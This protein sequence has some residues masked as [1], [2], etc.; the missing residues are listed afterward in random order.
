MTL[1]EKTIL[2]KQQLLQLKSRFFKNDPPESIKDRTF[3]K[4]MKEETKSTFQLLNEWESETLT[5]LQ[6]KQSTLYPQQIE[7]TSENMQMIILHSY[8]ID[9]RKRIYMEYF[10]STI[11]VFDQL[12][13]ELANEIGEV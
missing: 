7:A 4:Q 10:K 11:Y 12:L 13:S 5:F 8:Y 1:R 3:F 6:N 9:V 2:L